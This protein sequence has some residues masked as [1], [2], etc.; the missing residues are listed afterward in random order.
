MVKLMCTPFRINESILLCTLDKIA[1]GGGTLESLPTSHVV[2]EQPPSD[3]LGDSFK[4]LE[5]GF[6]L[7]IESEFLHGTT[8]PFLTFGSPS[9]STEHPVVPCLKS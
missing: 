3:D 6:G 4:D 9:L 1:F 7:L 5:W 2:T 8:S